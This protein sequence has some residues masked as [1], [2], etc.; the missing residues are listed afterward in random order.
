MKE[1]LIREVYRG[2]L[3]GYYRENKTLI[4]LR[5]HY[6]WLGMEKDVQD[7]LKMCITYQ[8][9]KSHSLPHSLYKPLPIPTTP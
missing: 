7:I 5:E 8:V 2:S 9:I 6:Y 1:L 3:A 4:M